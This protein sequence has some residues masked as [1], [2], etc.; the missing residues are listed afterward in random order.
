[1]SATSEAV[2]AWSDLTDD[3]RIYAIGL[4]AVDAP[5]QL[6]AAARIA[7]HGTADK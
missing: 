5:D 3:E 1:M 2:D 6:L 4:L 7:R